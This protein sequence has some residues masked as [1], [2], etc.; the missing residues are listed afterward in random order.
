MGEL[1]MMQ[2]NLCKAAGSIMHYWRRHRKT[3]I[4][5]TSLL[6]LL[7]YISLSSFACSHCYKFLPSECSL[8]LCW[9]EN[10]TPHWAV[11][12]FSWLMP[13]GFAR[14]GCSWSLH[15]RKALRLSWVRLLSTVIHNKVSEQK[16][17]AA[18]IWIHS[19]AVAWIISPPVLIYTV[20]PAKQ[21]PTLDYINIITA[22][23]MHRLSF[24]YNSDQD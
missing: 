1:E 6:P 22:A 15:F 5:Q 11:I 8:L 21:K 9:S 13:P 3:S 20:S 7:S 17:T 2:K 16:S 4:P 14:F 12:M 24:T 18:L 10:V 19:I 23:L